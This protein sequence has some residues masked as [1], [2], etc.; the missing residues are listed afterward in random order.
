MSLH[1]LVTADLYLYPAHTI[2]SNL[3]SFGKLAVRSSNHGIQ[4]GKVME[5]DFKVIWDLRAAR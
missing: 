1:F 4:V 2:N 5:S 3:I